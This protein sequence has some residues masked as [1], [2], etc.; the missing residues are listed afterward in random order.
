MTGPLPLTCGIMTGPMLAKAW[1]ASL[2]SSTTAFSRA[3][4]VQTIGVSLL[5]I[6]VP[7]TNLS[8]RMAPS[9]LAKRQ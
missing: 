2:H 6:F 8:A 9:A 7:C 5:P 1:R 3:P 4:I